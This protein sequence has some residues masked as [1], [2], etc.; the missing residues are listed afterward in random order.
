MAFT[1]GGLPAHGPRESWSAPHGLGKGLPSLV[2]QLYGRPCH[3]FVR[4]INEAICH[5]AGRAS[6]RMPEAAEDFANEQT[7]KEAPTNILTS[8]LAEASI[9]VWARGDGPWHQHIQNRLGPSGQRR[10]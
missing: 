7:S 8:F 2:I 3:T 9:C 1:A 5:L 6:L 10:R 4:S